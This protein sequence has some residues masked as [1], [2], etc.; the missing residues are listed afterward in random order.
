MLNSDRFLHAFNSIERYLRELTNQ[1]KETRFYVLVNL[2]GNSNFAVRRFRNDL[3]EFADLRN[4]IVHERTDNH[5]LAEPNDQAVNEIERITSLLLNPPKVIP[6]FQS[7]VYTL[8][9][10]DSI[11]KAAETMFAKSYSQI[12]IYDT[13]V[14]VGLL[15][16]NT[17][18]RWLGACVTEE[19]F[20]LTETSIANVLTYTE[21]KDNFSFLD[22]D[23]TMFEALERFQLYERKGKRLEAILITQTGKPSETLLGIITIWNLPKIH[24]T[25]G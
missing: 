6:Q 19:I 1:G 25:L 5:V 17:I 12:P 20:S 9:L 4:A 11:A 23:T 7:K 3:K 22:R 10:N 16:A 8:L 2:A 14:F 21:D 24:G 15:T 18:V 13:T